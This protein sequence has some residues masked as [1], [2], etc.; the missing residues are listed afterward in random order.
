MT[1]KNFVTN[2]IKRFTERDAQVGIVFNIT[3]EFQNYLERFF[4]T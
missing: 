4:F 3:T 1:M 2:V